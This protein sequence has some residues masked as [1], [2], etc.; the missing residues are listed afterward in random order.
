LPLT[1][2]AADYFATGEPPRRTGNDH[3]IVAPY[4]MFH[5]EDGEMALAPSQEDSYQRLLF[6]FPQAGRRPE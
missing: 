3:A 2:L 4:G 6:P 5:T 1:F